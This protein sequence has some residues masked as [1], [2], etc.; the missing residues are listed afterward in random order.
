MAVRRSR[1]SKHRLPAD[2]E[3]AVLEPQRLVDRRVR[4]VDVERR[5]L[6]LGQDLDLGRAE[7]DVARRQLRVLRARQALRDLRRGPSRTNSGRM[8]LGHLVRIRRVGPRIDDD[9]G[10]AVAVAQVQEDELAVVA[11]PVDP[12]GQAGLGTRVGR[13]QFPVRV[14]PVGRGEAGGEGAHGRRIVVDREGRSASRAQRRRSPRPRQD[15]GER[16]SDPSPVTVD[17]CPP[18]AISVSPSSR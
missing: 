10:D 11:P 4:L 6:R 18:A 16:P 1:R 3:I 15:P 17:A 2:V 5:R 8:R 12:A 9:L 7:L 13:P 14:G